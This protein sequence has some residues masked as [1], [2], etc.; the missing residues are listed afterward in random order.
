MDL[1]MERKLA[2]I[3][4]ADA[5]AYS[6]HMHDAEESTLLLLRDYRAVIDRLITD[7]RGRIF[8]TAGDSVLAEFSSPV[9]AVRCAME[10]QQAIASENAKLAEPHRMQFRIGI[11]L[12]DVVTDEGKLIGE[13]V[14]IAARLEALAD[15]GTI[16]ISEDVQHQIHHLL[17]LGFDD[18]GERRLKNIATPIRVYRVRAAPLPWWRQQLANQH[19]RHAVYVTTSALA[20]IAI[21][22][23]APAYFEW[24]PESWHSAFGRVSV[25]QASIAVLALKNISGNA[26]EEYFSDGLT[27]DITGELARFK[28]LFVVASNSSFTYKAKPAKAQDIGRDLGVAYILEGTVQ[29]QEGRVR[30]NAQLVDTQTGR[31][32]WVER[33]D[34]EGKDIFDI[35]DNI[36]KAVVTRLAVEVDM[37]EIKKITVNETSDASAYDHYLKGRQLFY[38]YTQDGNEAAKLEFADAIR[39][40]QNF[41]RAYG[42]LGYTHLVDIQ[43]GWTDNAEKSAALALELAHK[44]VELDPDDYYTH[45]NLASVYAGRKDMERALGEYNIALALN[46][47]DAD[48]LAEMADLFSYRGEADRAIQQIESAKHLNPHYPEWY[49]WSLGFAHFQKRQYTEAVAALEKMSDPP[50]TAYL[51][52]VA[53]KAK[54]GSETPLEQIM[55]HLRSKDPNWSPEH[56]NQFPFVKTEDQQHYLDSFRAIGIP[57]PK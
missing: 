23:S 1:A 6:R 47:N 20:A 33:Y 12:G 21:F 27:Q 40:D 37:A 43:E 4:V 13:G 2:A 18:L 34:R 41:A 28:N 15:P 36:I 5:V 3:L 17:K 56:L 45:W 11:H 46:S 39:L 32:V 57:V 50:N 53:S 55:S 8:S 35:Q 10:V 42:W 25:A 44:G 14:N 9:E 22:V 49:D 38:T 51:L 54:L 52:L 30:L 24:L 19:K 26:N 48:M 16:F 7:H 29:K 31:Q